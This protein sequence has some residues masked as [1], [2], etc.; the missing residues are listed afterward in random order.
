MNGKKKR[1]VSVH[2][3]LLCHVALITVMKEVQEIKAQ[4]EKKKER[5]ISHSTSKICIHTFIRHSYIV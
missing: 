5:K 2:F 1:I 4:K 3:T